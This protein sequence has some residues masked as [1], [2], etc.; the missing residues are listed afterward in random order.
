MTSTNFS[1][2]LPRVFA[3]YDEQ[4]IREVFDALFP[5]KAEDYNA[6]NP[7][8][9]SCVDHIDLLPRED[10]QGRPY[11]TAFVHFIDSLSEHL[12]NQ[13]YFNEFVRKINADEEQRIQYDH[14]WYWKCT[15]NKGKKRARGPRILTEADMEEVKTAQKKIQAEKLATYGPGDGPEPLSMEPMHPDAVAAL[16]VIEIPPQTC[17]MKRTPTQHVDWAEDQWDRV[18]A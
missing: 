11:Y 18:D 3:R 12:E 4:F 16:Q 2:C 17:G 7:D 1:V 9:W 13:E 6:N 8:S 5:L 15:K 14:P 10:K